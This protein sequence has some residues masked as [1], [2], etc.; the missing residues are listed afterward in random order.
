MFVTQQRCQ[1]F[2][3]P[4]TWEMPWQH[5]SSAAKTVSTRQHLPSK[6]TLC[7]CTLEEVLLCPSNSLISPLGYLSPPYGH[8]PPHNH[9]L[10]LENRLCKWMIKQK[11]EIILTFLFK[12]FLWLRSQKSI[13]LNQTVYPI[14]PCMSFIHSSTKRYCAHMFMIIYTSRA[15]FS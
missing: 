11:K 4:L 5:S 6:T 14:T 15:V 3:R 12:T 10:G 9:H 1:C 13:E 7:T 8:I 2:V